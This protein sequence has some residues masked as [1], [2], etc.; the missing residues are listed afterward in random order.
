MVLCSLIYFGLGGSTAGNAQG[1]WLPV[2]CSQQT[3]WSTVAGMEGI[4]VSLQ[5][6]KPV[7][8]TVG[9]LQL[10]SEV[11]SLLAMVSGRKGVCMIGG[12]WPQ[13][14]LLTWVQLSWTLVLS[15]VVGMQLTPVVSW[16]HMW[17]PSTSSAHSPAQKQT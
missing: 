4:S 17:Y 13:D 1:L 2:Q 14:C 10:G 5:P 16:H 8:P 3:L 15:L 11:E 7:P 9:L 6:L 12:T